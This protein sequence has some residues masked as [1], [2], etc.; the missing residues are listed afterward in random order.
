VGRAWNDRNR[1]RKRAYDRARRQR[2]RAAFTPA[3]RRQ[4]NARIWRR[5]EAKRRARRLAVLTR[6][7]FACVYCREVFAVAQLDV[8]HKQPRSRGG[9]DDAANLVTACKPCNKRKGTLTYEQFML[10]L[11]PTIT[12]AWVVDD[13]PRV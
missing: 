5:K 3:Q 9:T 11:D 4:E 8:D 10:M 6:D 12:P 1:D 7:G 2:L 13:E